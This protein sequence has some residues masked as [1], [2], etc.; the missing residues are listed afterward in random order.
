MNN[1]S[2]S[3]ENISELLTP[4]QELHDDLVRIEAKLDA[5]ANAKWEYKILVPNV[6]GDYDHDRHKSALGPLG[7][8]GWELITYSPDVGYILKRRV[9]PKP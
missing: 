1:S 4:L 3:S 7:A 5:F 2:G 8:E 9:M 6:L